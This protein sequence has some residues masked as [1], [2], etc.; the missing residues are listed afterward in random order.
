M[1]APEDLARMRGGRVYS[2]LDLPGGVSGDPLRAI[3]CGL[4]DAGFAVLLLARRGRDFRAA[5]A[6]HLARLEAY[7]GQVVTIRARLEAERARAA[8]D[9]RAAVRFGLGWLRL[10]PSGRV[11]EHSAEAAAV[12]G[13]RLQVNG[14]PEFT[15]T[16]AAR[17]FRQA[18][19][20]VQAGE[21]A[22]PVD[23]SRDPP[24]QMT[25]LSHDFGDGP[26]LAALLR[27]AP[28]A[29]DLPVGR[30]AATFGL[31][32]SEA[33]LAA[34]LCDG[35]SLAQAAGHLGWTI[36]TARSCSKQVFTRMGVQGQPGVVRRM[37]ASLVWLESGPDQAAGAMIP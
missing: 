2:Q 10:A 14:W 1:P 11:L 24:V 12:A 36:G 29:R 26:A 28:M 9:R 15:E 31:S 6:A 33:R 22:A 8:L 30:V 32:R 21:A 18:L 3:R 16:G 27:Q 25:V 35:F 7:L 37:Q 34:L 4:E 17:A 23:L 19:A 5:D 13:L 20:A